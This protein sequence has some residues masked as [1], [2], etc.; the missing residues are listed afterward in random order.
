MARKFIFGLA[1]LFAASSAVFSNAMTASAAD[2]DAPKTGVVKAGE[3]ERAPLLAQAAPAAAKVA[4]KKSAGPAKPTVTVVLKSAKELFDDLEFVMDLAN[5]PN[6]YKTL[7]GNID[8]FLTGVDRT[9]L[10]GVRS[11]LTKDGRFDHIL[12]LPI[13]SVAQLKIF[14]ANIDA[15]DVK[16]KLVRSNVYRLSKLFEGYLYYDGAYAHLG[17]KEADVV[18]MKGAPPAELLNSYDLAVVLD[19]RGQSIESRRK[20][21]DEIS[22]EMHKA[23]DQ[24]KKQ[25][26]EHEGDF[27]IRKAAAH[28]QIAELERYFVESSQLT[29]GWTTSAKNKNA[30]MNIDL[31]AVPETPLAA[32]IELIGKGTEDYSAISEQGAVVVASVNFPIDDMRKTHMLDLIKLSRPRTKQIIESNAKLSAAQKE[33]DKDLSELGLDIAEGIANI[34]IF[35]GFLRM[36][37]NEKPGEKS[38]YS[39]LGGGKV[40]DSDKVL[41]IL[42]RLA[43]HMGK[44]KVKLDVAKEGDVSIHTLAVPEKQQAE[45]PELFAKDSIAYIG[46]SKN[47]VWFAVGDKALDRLKGAIAAPKHPGD[48]KTASTAL[49]VHGRFLPWAEM[50]DTRLGKTGDVKL[51]KDALEAFK[52][53]KDTGSLKVIRVDKDVKVHMQVDEGVLRFAG[54]VMA[55]FVKES[56]E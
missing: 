55:K 56:L 28:Q 21:F 14:L 18:A 24:S 45:Y 46:T 52:E 41:K 5:A 10:I 26:Q 3:A 53:G 39:L 2:T 40:A 15:L 30:V 1:F 35:D 19:N 51:R 37:P 50:L 47:A 20:G 22:K 29:L 17:E 7:A 11:Y 27:K 8:V 42:N 44:E 12:S 6:Q 32:S 54:K 34:G 31:S 23:V 13:V 9:K 38:T 48:G 36:Y 4:E 16:S 43:E 33:V 49:D 25:D